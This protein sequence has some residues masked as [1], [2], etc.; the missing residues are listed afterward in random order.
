MSRIIQTV[1]DAEMVTA[2]RQLPYDADA[3]CE[4]PQSSGRCHDADHFFFNNP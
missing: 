1:I 4:K 3:I 2:G